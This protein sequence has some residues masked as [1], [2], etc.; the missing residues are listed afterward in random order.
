LAFGTTDL[1]SCIAIVVT[2]KAVIYSPTKAFE[3]VSSMEV[4]VELLLVPSDDD[5]Y[6]NPTIYLR[7]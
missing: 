3:A 6:N 1:E 2:V 7:R 5:N 4:M